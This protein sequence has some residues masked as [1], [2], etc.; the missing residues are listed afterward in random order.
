MV[1]LPVGSLF[2]PITYGPTNPAGLPI[3]LMAM[4]PAAAAPG[5][6]AVSRVPEHRQRGKGAKA[7]AGQGDHRAGRVE[8]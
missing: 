3:E 7:G 6:N 5:R 4:P 8:A 2:D 1:N